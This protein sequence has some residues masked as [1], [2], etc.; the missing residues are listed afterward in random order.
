MDEVGFED[1]TTL[2]SE[3]VQA[4]GLGG[5]NGVIAE[6]TEDT[7][8]GRPDSLT[9]AIPSGV[10]DPDSMPSTLR[11]PRWRQEEEPSVAETK[12]A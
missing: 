1:G 4:A 10:H 9:T 8:F 5:A 3:E 11:S 12:A 6:K 2:R 7:E